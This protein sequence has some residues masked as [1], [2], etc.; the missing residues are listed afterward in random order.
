MNAV[1]THEPEVAPQIP[2]VRCRFLRADEASNPGAALD[3]VL[4]AEPDGDAS[5]AGLARLLS[6][7]RERLVEL[8][9]EHGNVL[10]RGFDVAPEAFEGVVATGFDADRFLWMFPMAP[11]WARALLDLPL[12]GRITRAFLGWIE[13]AATGRAIVGDKQST[14]ADDQ[15]IQFPHH[16]YGIFF[17]V[18]RV[19]AF[20]CERE[21]ERQ[22][23][24]LLCDA[25]SGYVG[26]PSALRAHFESTEY[27]RYRSENQWYLPPFTAPAVL[28]HPDDS[29]P[30]MNFTAYQHDVFARV[31]ERWFPEHEITATSQDETFSFVPTFHRGEH[32]SR[33]LSEDQIVALAESHLERSV[34]LRWKQGDL[35]LM[36]NFRVVHGRLNAGMPERKVLQIV[37]CDY[38]RNANRFTV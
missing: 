13:S 27:I 6:E 7:Q 2:G 21:A 37:L 32:T 19:L 23:E 31:A 33:G 20:F 28:Y 17:N 35:L 34:L 18:P 9:R 11:R 5:A 38:I 24:T 15:T 4:V 22:G 25:R 36:D 1:S 30:S 12:V 14:L 16:E 10:F 26:M 3:L 8:M 29:H